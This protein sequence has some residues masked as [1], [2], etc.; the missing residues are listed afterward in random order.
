MAATFWRTIE[1]PGRRAILPAGVALL[2]LSLC[3]SAQD[4]KPAQT[5]S[6]AAPET[7]GL[8]P[9]NLAAV[10]ADVTGGKFGLLD[11]VLFIRCGKT[12]YEHS[13]THDYGQIYG[14]LAKK[15]GALNH[16]VHG[17]YN[18]FSTEFHP[19]YRGSDL[20]TMQSVTKT[21]TSITIGIAMTRGDFPAD[22]DTPVVKFF[23]AYKISNLD[24]R[25]RRMTLRHLMTM[26]TGLE[27]HEDLPNIDPRNPVNIMEGSHDWVQYTIDQPMANEPGSVWVYNSGAAQLLSH[28]FKQ[29]TGKRVDEY[30]AEH[31]FKPLGIRHYWKLTPTGL[32]DTEGGLYLSSRDLAK[33]GYLILRNGKWDEKQIVSAEWVKASVT[34]KVATEKGSTQYGYLWWLHPYGNTPGKF[35]WAAHGFGQQH[36]IIIPEYELIIVITGW[37]IPPSERVREGDWLELILST[38]DKQRACVSNEK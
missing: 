7:I 33:I 31:L 13:Y 20:H 11:S 29:V 36:L 9:T 17:Q 38:V 6:I 35:V 28:I 8:V 19:F 1:L 34:P 24:E 22:L 15:E 25:K 18:Y 27:W 12:G 5:W 37:N 26:T 21:V 16:D 4:R 2:V 14:E 30:A 10:D 3:T 23:G 32:P